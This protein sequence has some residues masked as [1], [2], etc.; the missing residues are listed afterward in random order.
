MGDAQHRVGRGGRL[1]CQAG[2]EA[3]QEPADHVARA[4]D[5]KRAKRGVQHGGGA[6]PRLATVSE[7]TRW[8][9]AM[10]VSTAPASVT[11]VTKAHAA[12]VARR[13]R[14]TRAL[15]GLAPP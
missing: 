4:A 11:A 12:A 6:T 15:L 2:P 7:V 14:V 8:P 5:D 3:K 9:D 1:D 10:T 13:E